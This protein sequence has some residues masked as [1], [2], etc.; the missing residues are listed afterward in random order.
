MYTVTDH[1]RNW[2]NP[3]RTRRCWKKT[4]TERIRECRADVGPLLAQYNLLYAVSLQ[5]PEEM[6][7][8]SFARAAGVGP[9]NLTS[10]VQLPSTSLENLTFHLAHPQR[11]LPY[12]TLPTHSPCDGTASS[13]LQHIKPKPWTSW[14]PQTLQEG[15]Q[16]PSWICIPFC[17]IRNQLRLLLLHAL[18]WLWHSNIHSWINTSS[19]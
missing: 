14:T 15:T 1:L 12:Y 17:H 3:F 10:N 8:F 4:R 6:D 16:H 11:D 5:S 18:H 9:L 7:V 19:L 13:T 2:R